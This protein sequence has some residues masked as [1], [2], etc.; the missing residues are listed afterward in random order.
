MTEPR[1]YP[2]KLEVRPL[3]RPL[4]AEVRVPG[5]KSMT[6]RALVLAALCSRTTSCHLVNVLRSED[7]EVMVESLRRLG[8]ALDV[9]WE[10]YTIHVRRHESPRLVPA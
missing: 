9:D 10:S 7:T 4:A 5:S 1:T 3:D 2:D 6:N 8:F